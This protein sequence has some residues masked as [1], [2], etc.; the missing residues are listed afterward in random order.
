M[1]YIKKAEFFKSVASVKDLPDNNFPE[2]VFAGR[3]NVGKSSLI[4]TLVNI[5]N[6][7][8][9]S[10]TPGK[11]RLIN[12]FSIDNRFYFVDLPGYGYAKV[13]ENEKEKW[14]KM[15]EGYFT[16]SRNIRLVILILDIRRGLTEKDNEMTAYLD[17]LDIPYALILTKYD[18]VS[19]NE[20][21]RILQSVI[22]STGCENVILYSSRT[23]FNRD[24]LINLIYSNV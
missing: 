4:N 14:K 22:G 17:H 11:T 8:K 24:E 18:K 10:Q 5:R 7:A 13:S 19:K 2:I 21:R 6:L 23:R 20:A 9:T 15:I 3:S 1:N 16:S 12:F